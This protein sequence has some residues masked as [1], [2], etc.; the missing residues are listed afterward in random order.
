MSIYLL[1]ATFL[2]AILIDEIVLPDV[3][4]QWQAAQ[5]DI[6]MMASLAR[7]ERSKGDWKRVVEESGLRIKDIIAYDDEVG[8]SIIFVVLPAD[9][10]LSIVERR[11]KRHS[12]RGK[13]PFVAQKGTYLYR[14]YFVKTRL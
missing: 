3:G 10:T 9:Q 5:L 7:R 11:S 13:L 14:L 2:P 1:S 8:D 12:N 6:G 4:A